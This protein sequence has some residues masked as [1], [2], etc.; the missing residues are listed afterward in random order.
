MLLFNRGEDN[1]EIHMDRY[2]HLVV[3]AVRFPMMG[4]NQLADLLL[5]KPVSKSHTDILVSILK[6]RKFA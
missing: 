5:Y 6:A 3:S 4:P 2:F 1:V